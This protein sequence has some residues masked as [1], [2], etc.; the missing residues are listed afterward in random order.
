MA[1]K[2]WPKG[3]LP[4]ILHH[5]TETLVAFEFTSNVVN[6]PHS[7]LFVGGLGDGL[8]T[9]PYVR[10]LVHAL[11]Q[12]PWSVF[13][14]NL[15]SSY[16][17]WGLG[18]LD[19]DTDEIAQCLNYIKDYKN[20]K[21]GPG[22]VALMGHSSGCQDILHYLSRPNP[23]TGKAPFDPNL[24]HVERPALDGAIMQAAVS[25]RQVVDLLLEQPEGFKGH[26]QT[27]L[28]ATFTQ[29]VAMSKDAEKA[30]QDCDTLLPL[31]MTSQIY[32]DDQVLT[33]RRF[34]SLVSPESPEKP[35]EDDLFSSDLGDE[36][37]QTTFGKI[38]E[39]G[40]LKTK[41]MVMQ[42]GADQSVPAWVDK[43]D[44]M[45]RWA[46][47]MGDQW[48]HESSG[49]IPNASHALSND[50]QEEPRK[51]LVRRVL[52]YLSTVLGDEG[53]RS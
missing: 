49:I 29:L 21:F 48:D 8:A 7:L 53:T 32:P 17:S 27:E 19:R 3:G 9:T 10:D 38:R 4:G 36:V 14:V 52:G 12:S 25:D 35:R 50:D 26:S 20:D 41:L 15:T 5:F 16:Q 45:G 33:A 28:K 6:K 39:R 22:K 31:W 42:S 24:E 46:K 44:L 18:H 43:E 13:T 47:I 51:D 2:F 40:L 1:S 23:A 37:L 11:E 30:R 34:L